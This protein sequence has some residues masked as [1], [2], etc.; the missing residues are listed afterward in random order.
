ML[1]PIVVLNIIQHKYSKT[2]NSIFIFPLRT[3]CFVLS[4]LSALT[5]APSVSAAQ[6]R[7]FS[8]NDV[9]QT[10]RILA[11]LTPCTEEA[12]ARYDVDR[13]GQLTIL[14]ATLIQRHLAGM[15]D[16]DSEYPESTTQDASEPEEPT[17]QTPT[18]EPTTE[19]RRATY[20]IPLDESVIVGINE[21]FHLTYSTDAEA[22]AYSVENPDIAEIT[23]DGEVL[24]KQT[25]STVIV[26]TADGCIRTEQP[27]TVGGEVTEFSLNIKNVNLGVGEAYDIDAVFPEGTAANACTFSSDDSSVAEVNPQSGVAAAVAV[28]K[29]TVT[30][31]LANGV[32]ASC[33][34]TVYPPAQTVSL[35]TSVA[36]LGIGESFDVNSTVPSGTASFFRRYYSD[37]PEIAEVTE[38]D[39]VITAVQEGTTTVRCITSTG[40]QATVAVTVTQ[41]PSTLTLKSTASQTIGC[42]YSLTAATDI[43][44]DSGRF[45]KW[46]S[47]NPSVV[48][49][50]QYKNNAATLK[51]KSL[52]TATLT[53]SGFNGISAA[54]KVTVTKSVVKCIDISTW[55][56]GSVD[57][58]KV[59]AS[60]IQYVI[61]RAGFSETKDNQFENNY[62]K[63]KAAGLKVGAYWY[64][65]AGTASGVQKEAAACLSALKG[66]T[67]DLPVYYDIE[68]TYLIYG[69]SQST[70]TDLAFTFGGKIKAAGYKPG[71]YA[72]GSVY[73]KNYKLNYDK[74]VKENYS[75]WD[76]EWASSNTVKCDIWQY[77]ETGR[78]NGITENVDMDII[79][80]LNIVV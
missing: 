20:L 73:A 71:V 33:T 59:R 22:L 30:C 72:S 76:A 64:M 37:N 45:F 10:Q 39:G 67:L 58:G 66:K 78:V 6:P 13:S 63:A 43:G 31:Q 44:G 56:G 18:V 16:I 41:A 11:D 19:A 3:S 4:A 24:P 34:V 8:V 62:K 53:V 49:I 26:C 61:I 2:V 46:S 17:T 79:Y 70:L 80:N 15:I 42:T 25:G 29:A 35:N 68:E 28:G 52:G 48:G 54:Y 75:I 51:P 1:L 5:A 27:L 23:A 47:S 36:T 60:G 12:L 65:C 50:T 14:D 7:T 9:T 57:F 69:L 21:T 77:S 38:A 40:A 55:Q 32:W 74:L